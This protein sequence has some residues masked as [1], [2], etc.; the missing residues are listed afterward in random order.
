MYVITSHTKERAK[1]AGLEVKP[2]TKSNKKLDVYA[3]GE[4]VASVGDRSY[5]DYG[6][7]LKEEGKDVAEE[8]RRLY[9]IRH[10]N[11]KGLEG[12]LA[13]ILLW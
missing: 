10:K 11:N 12:L 1:R 8:R 13:K 6:T 7:Y 2:S 4:L 3:N 9:H 5:S